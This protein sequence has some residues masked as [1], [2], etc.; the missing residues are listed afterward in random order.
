MP[1]IVKIVA[2]PPMGVGRKDYSESGEQS[3]QPSIIDY[4]LRYACY[5]RN[6]QDGTPWGTFFQFMDEHGDP[7]WLVPDVPY[8]LFDFFVSCARNVL[9]HV[10]LRSYDDTWGD[11]EIIA[12][13]DDYGAVHL[14][15]LSGYKLR[16]G[17]YYLIVTWIQADTPTTLTNQD[18]TVFGLRGQ[19]ETYP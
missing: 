13:A 2:V 12:A 14:N 5:L 10:D 17:R 16:T 4:Q 3:V 9:L 15:F 19:K 1:T 18:V 11:E 8:Y 6:L 7:V